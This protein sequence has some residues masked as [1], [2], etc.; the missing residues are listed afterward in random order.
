ME[1]HE[2]AFEPI[3]LGKRETA[4]ALGVCVRTVENL[5]ATKELP[6]RKIGRRTLIPYRA[7]QDFA[8]RDH[9][10]AGEVR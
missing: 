2:T 10:T 4:R 7:L 1:A 5:I 6:A 9:P 8:R 3:L